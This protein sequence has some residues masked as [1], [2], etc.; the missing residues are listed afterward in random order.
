MLDKFLLDI[1][2]KMNKSI[3]SLKN[4]F[5]KIIVNK[6]NSN[7]IKSLFISINND[8]VPLEHI[9]VISIESGNI[10]LV[11]PFDK[12]QTSIIC[13]ELVKLNMDL[14]PFVV[15]DSIKI[16]FP[17][18][19]MERRQFFVKKIK[20]FSEDTKVSIRNI[21]KNINQDVKIFLK[22]NKI[23]IDDEKKFFLSLQKSVDNY[24]DKV[25]FL[26]KKKENELLN[27]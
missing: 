10:V 1:E 2:I 14:N 19:T 12:H 15:N 26:T 8:K 20:K 18:V 27:I 24:I 23:S 6:V 3:D 17:L 4:D 9:S 13:S 7:L 5:S 22:A 16:V 11:K 25:D 21:R